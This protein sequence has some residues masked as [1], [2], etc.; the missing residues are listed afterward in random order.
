MKFHTVWSFFFSGTKKCLG[1]SH[2]KRVLY[3]TKKWLGGSIALALVH[4]PSP[5]KNVAPHV[6]AEFGFVDLAF[7]SKFPPD[8]LFEKGGALETT[9]VSAVA[10]LLTNPAEACP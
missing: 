5:E 3:R 8:F 1:N 2:S 6:D 7:F 9:L 10:C 4:W